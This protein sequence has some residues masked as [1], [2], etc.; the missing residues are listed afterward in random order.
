[1]TAAGHFEITNIEDTVS[2]SEV[3]LDFKKCVTVKGAGDWMA[4]WNTKL[5]NPTLTQAESTK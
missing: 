4:K 3:V 5:L 1:M 2:R